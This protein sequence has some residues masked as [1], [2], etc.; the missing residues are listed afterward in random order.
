MFRRV[1]LTAL[2]KIGTAVDPSFISLYL[3]FRIFIQKKIVV[4]Y[5]NFIL[6]DEEVKIT[7][8]QSAWST[9]KMRDE[10]ITACLRLF[11]NR[12]EKDKS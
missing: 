12:K 10:T 1:R 7:S 8:Y 11:P 3:L 4:V 5:T 6:R 9:P 2:K